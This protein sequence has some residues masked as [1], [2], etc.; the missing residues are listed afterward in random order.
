MGVFVFKNGLRNTSKKVYKSSKKSNMF[1]NNLWYQEFTSLWEAISH[2]YETLTAQMFA[3]TT[4]D[5]LRFV[6]TSRAEPDEIPAAALLTGI[7]MPDHEAQF[8]NLDKLLKDRITPHVAL[9]RSQQCG[10][11]KNLIESMIGQF[12]NNET[13]ITPSLPLL[14]RWYDD[15]YETETKKLKLAVI[16]PDFEAF[17]PKVL[18][19]FILIIS[20]YLHKLPFVLIFGIATSISSLYTSLPYHVISKINVQ[21]FKCQPS[22]VHL[23]NV[24]EELLF[25]PFCPFQLGGRVFDLFTEIF[26][27]YDFS[28]HN[29]VQNIKIAMM[30]HFCQGNA[31][32]LCQ[33]DK[34]GI[35]EVI[36][37]FEHDDYESVRHLL[38]FR[39]LVEAEPPE[40]R[41]KLLTD[42]QYLKMVLY[43]KVIAVQ[44]YTRRLHV[45]LKCLHVLVRDLPGAPM[46]KNIREIYALTVRKTITESQEYKEC[47]Q[48]LSFQS[49]DELSSKLEK[50]TKV[51]ECYINTGS[52][53]T[54]LKDFCMTIKRFKNELD[55]LDSI[56]VTN[57]EVESIQDVALSGL[58][59]R[60]ALKEALMSLSKQQIKPLNKYEKL[61]GEILNFLSKNFEI[62]MVHPSSLHLYEICFFDDISIK[63]KIVGTHRSAIHNA[64]NDPYYYLQCKCCEISN[65]RTV[66]ATMP[67]ICIAYK[68]HLEWGKMIN[69]YDW[70]LAFLCVVDPREDDDLDDKSKK[71]VNPELQARF[72]QAVAELEY[73]GFI[74]SSKRKMDHVMRLTWEG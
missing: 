51:M 7:N 8:K 34:R 63:D 3:S 71:V 36:D 56:D 55:V 43:D 26:L 35:K 4:S 18:Q 24:L 41:I 30:E 23:N 29:F 52:K 53:K 61:R 19:N 70:L 60:K 2:E 32:A 65:T 5:L 58:T 46:G 28:V 1:S 64:L 62:F 48:L 33:T 50:I 9:L 31:M 45:F 17:S 15:L 68:L 27:F 42:D 73:L 57:V 39:N 10:K 21:V 6:E 25:T 49:K 47:F 59:D 16:I 54:Q 40:N 44:K 37:L 13:T 74:K 66:K 72:T 38:S 12:L 20:S 22:I 11:L 69:L 14:Q 67:D